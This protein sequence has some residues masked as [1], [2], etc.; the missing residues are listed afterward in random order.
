MADALS[1]L[2]DSGELAAGDPLFTWSRFGR[3]RGLLVDLDGTLLD[4]EPVHRAAY[5]SF[6]A[7]RG[8][9]VDAG[10]YAH[11]VGRRGSDVFATTGA[12]GEDPGRPGRRSA[13]H[14]AGSTAMPVPIE[15]ATEL[16]RSYHAHGVPIAH[17]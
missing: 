15:G 4:S 6:F 11:F 2:R 1:D 12:G 9:T 3:V 16:I 5:E 14:L 13:G 10:T 7:A 17:Q 8:W